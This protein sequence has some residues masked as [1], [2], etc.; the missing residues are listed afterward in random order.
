MCLCPKFPVEN[1]ETD[2][3][4][5]CAHER[6]INLIKLFDGFRNPE[7]KCS[8]GAF[9]VECR[10]T[11]RGV[12]NRWLRWVPPNTVG[13]EVLGKGQVEKSSEAES[14]RSVRVESS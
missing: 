14:A 6:S 8:S 9:Q 10:E 5:L 1:L 3:Q 13:T 2:H 4:T 11:E 12:R 7:A